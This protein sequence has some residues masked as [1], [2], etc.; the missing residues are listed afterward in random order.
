MQL[1]DFEQKY[2]LSL[3]SSRL[4]RVQD[5]VMFCLRR[6]LGKTNDILIGDE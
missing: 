6:K 1:N 4:E 2:L 5:L 3:A